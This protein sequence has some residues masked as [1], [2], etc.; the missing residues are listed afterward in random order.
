MNVNDLANKMYNDGEYKQCIQLAEHHQDMP[1]VLFYAGLSYDSIKEKSTALDFF[2]KALALEPNHKLSLRA[3][4]WGSPDD[5]EQLEALEK[6]ARSNNAEA[7]DMS[8]MAEL[9][10]SHTRYNDAHYWYQRSLT[11]EPFNSLSLLGLA[12]LHARLAIKYLQDAEDS[13]DIDLSMQ[14]SSDRFAEDTLRYIYDNI[15]NRSTEVDD[16]TVN[17]YSNLP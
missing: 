11:A 10:T 14:M 12:D 9:Y 16:E 3:I 17:Y 1:D 7:D 4:G 15:I 2:R 13:K 8:L 6:L 5:V